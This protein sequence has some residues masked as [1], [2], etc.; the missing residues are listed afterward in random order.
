MP[1][2]TVAEGSSAYPARI[3]VSSP[4]HPRELRSLPHG[5]CVVQLGSLLSMGEHELLGTWFAEHPDA[6]LRVYAGLPATLDFL[7]AYPRLTALTVDSEVTDAS[8]LAFLPDSL[9]S[10]I[11]DCRLPQPNDLDALARF[12]SLDTLGLSGIRRLPDSV[13]GL[14]VTKLHLGNVKIL[15]GLG[16]LPHLRTLR[17]R[18]ASADLTPLIG[19]SYLEDL[20]LAVGGCGDLG[21]LAELSSLRRFSAWLVRGLDDVSPLARLPK[22]E[23]A[24]LSKLRGVDRLPPLVDAQSLA[25][26]T[27]EHMR[28]LSDLGPLRDAPALRLLSLIEMEHLQPEDVAVLVG[29]PTLTQVHIGLGSDRKNLAVRDALRISGSYGGHPWPPA[30]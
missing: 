22:L 1:V 3:E 29:H 21:P 25:K 11:I 5:R 20:T 13:R 2:I 18:N 14:P 26:V 30:N 10:L 12:R 4:L 17:L 7:R 19:L 8:G 27:L 15:D 6:E 16:H 23:D 28:G 24:Y 9:R